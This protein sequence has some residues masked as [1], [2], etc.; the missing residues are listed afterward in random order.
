MLW[1]VGSADATKKLLV[2]YVGG[3]LPGS[4]LK[5]AFTLKAAAERLECIVMSNM[6]MVPMTK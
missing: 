6:A 2:V 3:L 1:S 5:L 4:L